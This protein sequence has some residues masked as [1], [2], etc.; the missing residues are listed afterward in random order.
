[1]LRINR[2]PQLSKPEDF[3]EVT[4]YKFGLLYDPE[5]LWPSII[6]HGTGCQ[7][8]L[9]IVVTASNY[10]NFTLRQILFDVSKT[11]AYSAISMTPEM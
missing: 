1:M 6:L 4:S 10:R 9:V 11:A 3:S 5:N 8:M 7:N 2:A